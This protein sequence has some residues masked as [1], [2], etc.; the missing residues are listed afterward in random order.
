[1]S[2]IERI[3][4]SFAPDS[5]AALE[6][7]DTKAHQARRATTTTM[8]AALDGLQ[9]VR[10]RVRVREAYHVGLMVEGCD[11]RN[12][13]RWVSPALTALVRLGLVD[14][15]SGPSYVGTHYTLSDAGLAYEVPEAA[16][17]PGVPEP[18][19]PAPTP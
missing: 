13:G 2:R 5:W 4:R 11:R 7:R 1:M 14:R 16:P 15:L 8:A 9:R 6:G 18:G 10:A 12:P 19:A 17:E 3:A